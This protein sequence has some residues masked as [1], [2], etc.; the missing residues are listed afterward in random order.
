M[1]E[2]PAPSVSSSPWYEMG[3]VSSVKPAALRAAVRKREDSISTV[4]REQGIVTV[5][6]QVVSLVAQ[7]W[8]KAF[9]CKV[10][11][12]T[13]LEQDPWADPQQ[14]CDIVGWQVSSAGSTMEWMAKVEADDPIRDF[15]TVSEW[16]E[17][18]VGYANPAFVILD[19]RE[20]GTGR[21]CTLLA[22]Q[23]SIQALV[24]TE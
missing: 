15:A 20:Q 7:R 19:G 3:P 12:Q 13:G 10:T 21:A 1:R 5:H 8:A 6:D 16:N 11:I 23:S 24:S 17:A 9:H 22:Q 14:Q 18:V 2:I 4:L